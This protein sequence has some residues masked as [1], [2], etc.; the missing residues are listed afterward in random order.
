MELDAIMLSEI[1]K[2]RFHMISL[3]WN[4]KKKRDEHGAGEE[5]GKSGNRLLTIENKLK[6]IKG[7]MGG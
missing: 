2:D 5:R 7:E 4:L 3:I 1:E 6:V